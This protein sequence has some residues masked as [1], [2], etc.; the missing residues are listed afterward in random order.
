[1]Q[2]KQQCCCCCSAKPHAFNNTP[3]PLRGGHPQPGWL[4]STL[5]A[6]DRS[7]TAVG[8][9]GGAW[10]HDMR[11]V[12]VV[13]KELNIRIFIHKEIDILIFVSKEQ[14]KKK[15]EFAQWNIPTN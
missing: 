15:L 8:L 2:Q 7:R 3:C 9:T 12:L 13:R 10:R 5:V 11:C 1:M 6:K 14:D 4:L